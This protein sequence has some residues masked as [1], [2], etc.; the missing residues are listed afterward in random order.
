MDSM[1]NESL[2]AY[3]KDNGAAFGRFVSADSCE[4]PR[5]VG[6]I[7]GYHHSQYKLAVIDYRLDSRFLH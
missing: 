6:I 4:L 3:K 5:A 2:F 1:I 7:T